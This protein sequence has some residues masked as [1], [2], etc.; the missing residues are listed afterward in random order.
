MYRLLTIFSS[1]STIY[2]HSRD[3]KLSKLAM[4]LHPGTNGTANSQSDG[5]NSTNGGN[6]VVEDGKRV[7]SAKVPELTKLNSLEVT[8]LLLFLFLNHKMYTFLYSFI[9]LIHIAIVT[10]VYRPHLLSHSSKFCIRFLMTALRTRK[11]MYQM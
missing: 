6:G 11:K 4:D 3:K 1:F 8:N 2:L 10:S 5:L 9:T 7:H